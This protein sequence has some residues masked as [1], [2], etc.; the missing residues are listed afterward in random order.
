[1][2]KINRK[3]VKKSQYSGSFA[4]CG[5]LIDGGHGWWNGNSASPDNDYSFQL[6]ME[7][8]TST[9]PTIMVDCSPGNIGINDAIG[10][11]FTPQITG[12]MTNIAIWIKPQLYYVSSYELEIYSGDFS[13]QN[14]ELLVTSDQLDINHS[15]PSSWENL[16]PGEAKFY[17]FVFPEEPKVQFVSGTMYSWYDFTLSVFFF[18][19]F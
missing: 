6:Y 17:D 18:F 19:F 16:E 10:Q 9:T 11:S 4:E 12:K 14:P 5:N 1:M 8:D 15:E 7:A 3:L 2:N 13:L